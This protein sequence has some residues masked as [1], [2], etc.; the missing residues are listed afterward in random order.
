M[1]SIH[2]CAETKL[3]VVLKQNKTKQNNNN[4]KKNA[5]IGGNS[6]LVVIITIIYQWQYPLQYPVESR[7]LENAYLIKAFCNYNEMAASEH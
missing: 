4:N 1:V 2:S 3:K 6:H 5:R 7:G